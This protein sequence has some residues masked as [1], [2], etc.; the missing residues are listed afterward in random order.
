MEALEDDCELIAVLKA[1][2]ET[3]Y[4]FGTIVRLLVMTGQRRSEV[5]G[6]RWQEIDVQTL[7]GQFPQMR[8]SQ[9]GNTSCH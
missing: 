2:D 8:T 4:S 7:F 6:M 1:A 3:G 5:G 9:V